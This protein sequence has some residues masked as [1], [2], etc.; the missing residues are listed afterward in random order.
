VKVTLKAANYPEGPK[1]DFGPYSM[2]PTTQFFNPRV[3]ARYVAL[4]YDWEPLLGFSARVGACT[5]RVKPA[6]RRP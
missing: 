1:H 2:T 5:Y 6:G 3:R 4:R